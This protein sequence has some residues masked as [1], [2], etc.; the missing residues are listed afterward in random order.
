MKEET[1]R[2]ALVAGKILFA[3]ILLALAIGIADL[4]GRKAGNH[5]TGVGESANYLLGG[6]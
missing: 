5:Y 1:K 2:G 3:L 4:T 6:K